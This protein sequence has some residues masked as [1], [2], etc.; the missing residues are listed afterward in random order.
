MRWASDRRFVCRLCC[1]CGFLFFFFCYSPEC[2]YSVDGFSFSHSLNTTTAM[3]IIHYFV[4]LFVLGFC[5]HRENL[6]YVR[7]CCSVCCCF[8]CSRKFLLNL[9]KRA[10][11]LAPAHTKK[12]YFFFRFV[13]IYSYMNDTNT[14]R[15]YYLISS[16]VSVFR[17]RYCSEMR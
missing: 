2:P 16:W 1:C 12:C 11:N 4:I 5:F 7:P 14:H 13:F 9:C 6:K 8:R 3:L 10:V 15:Q 17:V